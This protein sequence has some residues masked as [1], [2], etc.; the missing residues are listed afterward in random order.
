MR[1]AAKAAADINSGIWNSRLTQARRMGDGAAELRARSGRVKSK[2]KGTK[3]F[4]ACKACLRKR[5]IS[6]TD[7]V[8]GRHGRWAS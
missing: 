5:R 1:W 6:E 2:T 4:W 7:I 8:S 3:G